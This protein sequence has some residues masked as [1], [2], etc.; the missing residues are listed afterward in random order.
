MTIKV[1]SNALRIRSPKGVSD[2]KRLSW[3]IHI[4]YLTSNEPNNTVHQLL[5]LRVVDALDHL[6]VRNVNVMMPRSYIAEIKSASK[7]ALL[8]PK[9]IATESM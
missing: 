1:L 8:I 7:E 5:C 9:Y 3:F 2:F 6:C 4:P